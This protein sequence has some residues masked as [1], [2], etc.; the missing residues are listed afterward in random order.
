MP[1]LSDVRPHLRA[2]LDICAERDLQITVPGLCGLPMC[3][4]PGYEHRFEEFHQGF[5]VLPENRRYAAVCQRC[6]QRG[7]CSGF[8]TVYFEWFGEDELGYPPDTLPL[9]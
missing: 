8:W 7:R 4:L 1:R 5:A 2:A 6:H 9:G 3:I